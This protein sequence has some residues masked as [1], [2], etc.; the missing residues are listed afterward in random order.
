MIG[1]FVFLHAILQSVSKMVIEFLF[2]D[3]REK[4]CGFKE[5]LHVNLKLPGSA[6]WG[7]LPI[8]VSSTS[9]QC[10]FWKEITSITVKICSIEHCNLVRRDVNS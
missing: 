9:Q 8:G 10:I 1:K 4:K 3:F 7:G 5:N 2:Q 6:M